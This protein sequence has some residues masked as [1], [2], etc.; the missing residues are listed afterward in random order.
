PTEQPATVPAGDG[1]AAFD[2]AV[3]GCPGDH[4][5]TLLH[6]LRMGRRPL[7]GEPT[8]DHLLS[9]PARTDPTD[10]C[11]SINERAMVVVVGSGAA[12]HERRQPLWD[13]CGEPDAD[14]STE[15]QPAES[16]PLDTEPIQQRQGI[17]GEVLDRVG[18][19]RDRRSAMPPMVIAQHLELLGQ[20]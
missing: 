8:G 2:V 15:G 7:R 16:R 18:P 4:L 3:I 13:T 20:R 19:V 6:Y 10:R 1:G 12:Q 14:H 17:E 11:C 9:Y 5:D